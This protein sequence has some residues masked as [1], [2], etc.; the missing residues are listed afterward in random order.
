MTGTVLAILAMAP[1]VLFLLS[2]L[3]YQ[4]YVARWQKN[5]ATPA[6]YPRVT[7]IAPQRGPIDPVSIEALLAQEYVG[8]WEVIF[9]TTK[10]DVAYGQLQPYAEEHANVRLVQARD[11]V[12]LAQMEGIHRGQKSENL[13]A[14]IE[15]SHPD[16]EF[17]ATIDADVWPS[18]E[19]L[20]SLVEPFFRTTSP[21]AATTMAR[22]SLPGANWASCAH[23]CWTLGSVC[24]LLAPTI[25]TWGGSMAFPKKIIE[26]TNVLERWRGRR[27][28]ISTDDLHLGMA[29]RQAKWASW[30]RNYGI[31]FVPGAMGMSRPPGRD[32]SVADL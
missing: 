1:S 17:F 16:T 6:S 20:R 8:P 15:A 2:A 28:S 29:L 30:R 14:A 25:F 5:T 10:E 24:Y 18:R 9:V 13:L 23:A 4:L 26:E 21:L 19:W 12:R 7:V 32:P 11:V 31:G 27:G 3:A 22:L